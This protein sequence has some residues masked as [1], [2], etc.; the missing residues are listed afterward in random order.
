MAVRVAVDVGGTFTDV[1]MEDAG[2]LDLAKAPTTAGRAFGGLSEAMAQHASRRGESVHE[3][4]TKTELLVYATTRSTNAI[5]AKG[6]ART[7]FITTKG[8]GDT[9]VLREGGKSNPF[10]FGTPYPAPY[11]PRR[12]TYEVSERVS[13]DGEV[14]VPLDEAGAQAVL[15]RLSA[16]RVEAVAV[17]LL[18][19]I[20]NPVHEERI[21]ELI[22]MTLPGVP[23]TLSHRLNPVVRE[24]R[25]AAGAAIDA[26]LK[27]LMQDHFKGLAA[28]L[29]E[30]GFSGEFLVVTSL[31]GVQDADDIREQP[32]FSVNSGPAMAPV[33]ALAY[34]EADSTAV[35]TDMGGTTFDVSIVRHGDPVT[36]RDTWLGERYVSD[37]TGLS[38]V[39]VRSIGA[40]GGSIAHI[41]SGGMLHVGPR[42]A[43]A[44]PGPACY[45]AGGSEATVTDAAVVLG[46]I[47]PAF[48]LGG[49]IELDLEAAERAVLTCVARPLGLDLDRAAYS[50]FRVANARMATHLRD[51]VMS[52]G[53][54]PRRA[55]LV[56]GGGAGGM[57]ATDLAESLGTD[58][59]VVPRTAA[60]LSACGGLFSDIVAEVA[61]SHY[62]TTAAFDLDRVNAVLAQLEDRADRFL[63]R[64]RS[65]ATAT[66]KDYLVEARYPSQAWELP[67]ELPHSR[68]GGAADVAALRHAFDQ[69]HE[70]LFAVSQPGHDVECL[71]WK[72]R[73]RAVLERPQLDLT[74][75]AVTGP[76][77][78]HTAAYFEDGRA[79]MPRFHGAEL[80][81]GTSLD[82]PLAVDEPTTTVLVPPGWTLEVGARP[83]YDLVRSM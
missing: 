29:R 3:L 52:H 80:A 64:V 61:T 35:V 11:V 15:G 39:D 65:R 12:L 69:A 44:D 31:G 1:A 56:A 14:Q 62:A 59:V 82:G 19:S 47:D 49:R 76:P 22:E 18:W 23:F 7:A 38:A 58:R 17:C 45:G 83:A 70:R 71:S 2:R 27:P 77:R 28:D 66:R 26:S 25:R 60:A 24:Y 43:G 8:F 41:D 34:L 48:F 78:G 42:S 73:A 53:L 13:S 37:I 81:P 57:I 40:G 9:L 68:F 51:F 6:A 55:V 72:V 32:I 21:G 20:A 46:Y 74:T 79:R 75:R 50:I 30:A 36:T 67:V 10:D 63:G 16:A 4:L 54:D 33:G 5:H